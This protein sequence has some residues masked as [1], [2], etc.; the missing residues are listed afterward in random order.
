M[1]I[2]PISQRS[3][4]E[5]AARF[6]ETILKGKQILET[7]GLRKSAFLCHSHK[8]DELVKGLLAE[9]QESGFDLYVDWKDHT[10]P[11]PP[12]VETAQK[13]QSKIKGCDLFLFLA[14]ANSKA[15]RWCPW[16]IGYADASTRRIYIIPTADSQDSYGNE[17]LE[18]Y[19]KIDEGV[20]EGRKG[21]AIF[22]VGKSSGRWLSAS[23]L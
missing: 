16:E 2:V 23:N 3:L 18:L 9:F 14:T 1:K 5:K 4:L 20:Y 19:P 7:G 10:M 13:I 21:L 8:D 6:Q 11:D 12:N 15:S 22:E 17:Y